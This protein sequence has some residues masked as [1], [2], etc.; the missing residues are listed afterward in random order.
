MGQFKK[1]GDSSADI[2][3]VDPSASQYDQI[4]QKFKS[5]GVDLLMWFCDIGCG[6]RF[7]QAAQSAQ[8]HPK[9]V[10]YQIG[11]DPAMRPSLG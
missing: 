3:T 9:R 11:Y 10:N 7:V 5:D 6:Q 8:Y 1:L 2:Q 4:V